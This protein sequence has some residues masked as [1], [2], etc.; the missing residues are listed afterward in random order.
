QK[1]LAEKRAEAKR[2]EKLLKST[3]E[4][5][6]LIRAELHELKE[7]YQDPR[8]TRIVSDA[9]EPSFDAEAFIV[10]EDAMVVLSAQGWI[11]RQQRI[12]DVGATRVRD[13]DAVLEVVAGSTRASVAFFSSLGVCYVMRIVDVPAT[14]G[15]GVPVQTLFKMEDGERI[16]AMMSFD[17]R[18]LDVPAPTEGAEPEEPYAVAVTK[19]GQS[20][21]FSLRA[22]RDPSTRAG[23]KYTR[24]AKDDA[25]VYVG[26]AGEEDNIACATLEGR[27]LICP[28]EEV[29]LLS[30][31]G[32]GVMLIKLSKGD[33]VIGAQVLT[34]DDDALMVESGGGKKLAVSTSKYDV[35]SRA[36]KGFQ[37]IKRGN[38]ERVLMD[39][40][41]LPGFPSPGGEG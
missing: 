5:W 4:R 13:G 2:I 35:V 36:G 14:T 17:P 39:E 6:K 12:K 27:A 29:A 18:F 23:R 41:T 37:L 21:R 8:R 10:D 15:Y 3:P 24:P 28:V 1:E 25:V 34:D 26:L 22:H 30:G 40:P 38:L 7:K 20:L 9:D 31:A 32:K 16:V 11:K 33:H 19:G